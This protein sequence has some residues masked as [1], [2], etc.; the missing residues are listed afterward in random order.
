MNSMMRR[1]K[2]RKNVICS[3][4]KLK[5]ELEAYVLIWKGVESIFALVTILLL[6]PCYVLKNNVGNLYSSNCFLY[7]IIHF[8]CRE[9]RSSEHAKYWNFSAMQRVSMYRFGWHFFFL[10][11]KMNNLF[12]VEAVCFSSI[13]FVFLLFLLLFC[14]CG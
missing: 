6:M 14:I 12:L 3:P 1:R 11:W 5:G 8:V 4:R 10:L 13:M 2:L 7:D 9:I